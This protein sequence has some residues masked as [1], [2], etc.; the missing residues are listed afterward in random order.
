MSAS[1]FLRDF[2]GYQLIVFSLLVIMFARFFREG[3]W[4]LVARRLR[5]AA[6]RPR[7]PDEPMAASVDRRE[8]ILR[9]PRRRRQRELRTS[10]HGELVGLI[11]PNGSGKT[12][13]L[14]ILS[15]HLSR[16]IPA[17]VLLDGKPITGLQPEQL[18]RLGVLRMFQLTRVFPRMSA[19]DNLLVAGRALGLHAAEAR[20]RARSS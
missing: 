10:R 20:A 9:R 17:T 5:A 11:G 18:A 1:E 19:L 16:P 15:G 6:L 3:L 14:N 13:L 7:H 4:G 12:T 2:G 8:Q